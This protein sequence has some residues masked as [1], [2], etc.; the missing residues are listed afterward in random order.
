MWI[1]GLIVCL[2]WILSLCFHEFSHAFVAYWGGDTTVKDKG[3]L[4]FNPIK[5]TE[6]GLSLIM[7]LVFILIGGIGLP[8]GAVYINH[9]LLRDR[10][11]SSCVSAAGPV[12]NILFAFLLAIPFWLINFT[13][14]NTGLLIKIILPSFAYLIYIE[15]FAVI[16][17]LLPI[18]PF[19]GYGI[20]EP[21]LTKEV[22]LKFNKYG[23]YS[24]FAIFGLFLFVPQFG[25][26]FS[27]IIEFFSNSIGISEAFI[28]QGMVLFYRPINKFMAILIILLIAYLLRFNEH[29]WYQKGNNLAREKK[30]E[31]ALAAYDQA[32]NIKSN[33]ID[34]WLEKGNCLFRLHRYKEAAQ[35]YQQTIKLA[36]NNYDAW[37]NLGHVSFNNRNCQQAVEAYQKAINLD[38]NQNNYL[39]V[40]NLAN[41][42]FYGNRQ[43]EAIAFL[44]ARI[45]INPNE[46]SLWTVQANYL[47]DLKKYQEAI[48]LCQEAITIYPQNS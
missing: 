11:W 31:K 43:Q 30:E 24:Y 8:G 44:Q 45:K 39:N 12:S 23:K 4:T 32:I 16:F 25:Y 28:S 33:Y 15:I 34:A 6:P 18:P 13:E 1:T 17:N 20:I 26:F 37:L 9:Q 46:A 21:W 47:Y 48:N 19:D 22:Q 2:G 35:S 41:A 14:A 42:L 40:L 3:Y 10:Y 5:Y 27:D 7:P 29:T 36:P 38:S